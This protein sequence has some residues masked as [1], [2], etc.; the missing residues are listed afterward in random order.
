LLVEAARAAI[1]EGKIASPSIPVIPVLCHTVVAHVS[2][3]Q[4]HLT[5]DFARE[6]FSRRVVHVRGLTGDRITSR[7]RMATRDNCGALAYFATSEVV[8]PHCING[9]YIFDG[10]AITQWLCE[11]PRCIIQCLE[12]YLAYRC[13]GPGLPLANLVAFQPPPDTTGA[14]Q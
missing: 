11:R 4:A 2:L 3:S 12:T 8:I 5:P 14:V 13:L 9:S 1:V 6:T 10:C 7:A